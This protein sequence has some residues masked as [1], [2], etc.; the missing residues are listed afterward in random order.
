MSNYSA[1]DLLN[2]IKQLRTHTD[3]SSKEKRWIQL[4]LS[5][6]Q[7]TKIIPSLS[8]VALHILSILE[9]KDLTGIDLANKLNVTRGGI[10]RAAQKLITNNLVQTFKHEDDQKRIYYSLTSQGAKIAKVHDQMHMRINN[11]FEQFIKNKYSSADLNLIG[12]FLSDILLMENNFD[13]EKA[14]SD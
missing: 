1:N 6:P 9:K 4:H 10:T 13:T 3:S 8:V 7:L 14:E 2:L 11:K 5:D 12:G